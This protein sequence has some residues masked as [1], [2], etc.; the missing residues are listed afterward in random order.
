MACVYILR[1]GNENLFKIGKSGD[2]EDR[3]RG[4]TTGNPRLVVFDKIETEDEEDHDE[5]N[6]TSYS[7][8]QRLRRKGR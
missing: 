5:K 8:H 4:L 1:S 2:V 7:K 6:K 3:V